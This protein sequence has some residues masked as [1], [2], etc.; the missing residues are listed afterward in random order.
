M[1]IILII[2]VFLVLLGVI[3]YFFVPLKMI[4]TNAERIDQGEKKVPLYEYYETVKMQ[5]DI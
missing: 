5:R 1:K 2:L 3:V 4:T